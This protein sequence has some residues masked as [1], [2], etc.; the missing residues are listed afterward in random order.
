MFGDPQILAVKAEL[1]DSM[2]LKPEAS[3]AETARLTNWYAVSFFNKILKNENAYSR[4]LANST[5][6]QRR[7]QLVRLVKN[8]QKVKAHPI[9]LLPMDKITFEPVGN[10]GYQVSVSSG[11]SFYEQ[12][13]D[14]LNLGG[15]GVANL[16]FPE[17]SFPVPGIPDPIQNPYCQ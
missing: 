10:A 7:N 3:V 15:D 13:G 6:N 8:R 9:D 11:A 1:I 2:P 5:T 14:N 4:Y 17:F 16:N 12:G